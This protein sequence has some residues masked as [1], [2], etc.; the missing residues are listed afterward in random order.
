MRKLTAIGFALVAILAMSAVAAT[1]AHAEQEGHFTTT[2]L[3]DRHAN[4]LVTADDQAQ[5]LVLEKPDGSTTTCVE[6]VFHGTVPGTAKTLTIEPTFGGSNKPR[7]DGPCVSGELPATIEE[8]GCHLELYT[9]ETDSGPVDWRM[10]SRIT[11]CEAGGI[12]IQVFAGDAH[13][14][15]V[16]NILIP[17]QQGLEGVKTSTEG[18]FGFHDLKLGVDIQDQIAYT[19][20]GLCT[21]NEH[22]QGKASLSGALT[23]SAAEDPGGFPADLTISHTQ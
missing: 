10:L 2:D 16:C 9:L 7:S 22:R 4:A 18:T 12:E 8:N 19:E 21:L 17:E 20:T 14:F 15:E 1:A 6:D 13:G 23:M 5:N 11:S 3:F